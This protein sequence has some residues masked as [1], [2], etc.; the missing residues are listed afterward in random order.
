MPNASAEVAATNGSASP[1][2]KGKMPRGITAMGARPYR[3]Q[4]IPTSLLRSGAY[5]VRTDL[6]SDGAAVPELAESI[7]AAGI[8]EPL[9]VRQADDG[10]YEVVA[11]ER[12]LLAARSLQ[13]REVPRIVTECTK[14]E[15]LMISLTENVQ[16]TDLNPMEKAYGLSR[17]L[18]DFALTQ[19]EI[20]WRIGMSQSAIAH[21]LRLLV[22]PAEVQELIKNGTL[23]MGHGKVLAGLGDKKQ[24]V[25][26]AL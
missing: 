18:E 17:L 11:G 9:V 14:N 8:I 3:L 1:L 23:S 20:G 13:L 6:A 10:T 12:R 4:P 2:P 26:L 5:T 15:A 19:E 24:A 25:A 22:L 16:R 7:A 21:H